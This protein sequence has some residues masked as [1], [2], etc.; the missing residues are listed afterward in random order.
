[1]T[2][3]IRDNTSPGSAKTDLATLPAF[4]A[5]DNK[6]TAAD[7]E[8]FRQALLSIQLYLR[9]GLL[10]VPSPTVV[11]GLTVSNADSPTV[12]PETDHTGFRGRWSFG[13]DVANA[14]TS[15]D[16]V[17]CAVRQIFSISDGAITGGSSTLTSASDGNFFAGTMVGSTVSGTGIPN[18]TTVV[19]VAGPTSLTMSAAA[20]TTATGVAVTFT[21]SGT[22]DLMYWKHRGGRSPTL[23]IGLTPPSGAARLQVS[24]QDD[25]PA[26]GTLR[27]RVGPSQTGN[28]LTVHDSNPVDQWWIDSQFFMSSA[29]GQG[30]K[31]QAEASATGKALVLA[32]NA[33]TLAYSL[34]LPTGSGGVLRLRYDTGGLTILE[35]GTDGS[36]RHVST[37]LGVFGATPVVKP[38]VTGSRGG[39]AALASLLAAGAS[40]GLWTDS[41]TA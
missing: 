5:S 18:G 22:Q 28:A 19:S 7:W 1:V 40:L 38:T 26:M 24:P 9:T 16:F 14:P 41:T 12:G 11:R 32:D 4:I 34:G 27:V 21:S 35:A 6:L 33:K 30:V 37:K 8:L 29:S 13:I 15:R 3:F 31:V 39:N 17:S 23:G 36:L 2:D 20:T 25:E 10:D